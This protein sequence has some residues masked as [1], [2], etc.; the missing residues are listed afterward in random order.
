M[1]QYKK[2]MAMGVQLPP[3]KWDADRKQPMLPPLPPEIE[4]RIAQASA[5]AMQQMMAQLA[6]QQAQQEQ[7]KQAQAGGPSPQEKMQVRQQDFQHQ[8]QLKDAAFQAEQQR[9]NASTVAQVDREDALQGLDPKL[10]KS[11]Q[12]FIT[13]TGLPMS[14]REL[15]VLSKALGTPFAKVVEAL[16][17]MQMSG[18]GGS[19]MPQLENFAH[20]PAR[21]T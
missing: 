5:Q 11:A 14:A 15:A 7:A 19:Q 10:V 16:S 2:F 13:Q 21:F 9:K 18:Q 4:M 8:Q 1:E 3:I 6:Q 20:N 17:R 12:E